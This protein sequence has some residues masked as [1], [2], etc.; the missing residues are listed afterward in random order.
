[1]I[2][3]LE[4]VFEAI[5]YFSVCAFFYWV[6]KQWQYVMLPTLVLALIGSIVTAVYLPESPR[7]LVSINKFD[8]ARY[9]FQII[10]QYNLRGIKRSRREDSS[11]LFKDIIFK[12]E[13]DY[14]SNANR[15][16]IY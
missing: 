16:L 14:L 4:F 12:E 11:P 1:M 8:Q 13:I 2:G 3:S 6:S 15:D 5:A 10:S 9:V 7:Y